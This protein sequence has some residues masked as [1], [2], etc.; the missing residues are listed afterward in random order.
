MIPQQPNFNVGVNRVPGT[1]YDN[2]SSEELAKLINAAHKAKTGR[3][4]NVSPNL[5]IIP[6]KKFVDLDAIVGGNG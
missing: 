3:Q 5:N 1:E 2:L 6:A 4:G